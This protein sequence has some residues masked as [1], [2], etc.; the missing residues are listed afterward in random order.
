[1]SWHLIVL[2]VL[3]GLNIV[4]TVKI[5]RSDLL[6][7]QQ[8]ALQILLVWLIPIVGA[9]VCLMVNASHAPERDRTRDP[10]F[11]PIEAGWDVVPRQPGAGD[12]D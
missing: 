4:A 5:L 3:V 2:I 1:M 7:P 9:T 12:G 8:R 10:N 11:H 6:G